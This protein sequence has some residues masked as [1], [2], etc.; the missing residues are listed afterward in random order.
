MFVREQEF[1]PMRRRRKSR[2]ANSMEERFAA[3][4]DLLRLRWQYEPHTF[5]LRRRFD[6]SPMVAFTPDFYLEEFDLYVELTM[7]KRRL[8]TLKNRKVRLMREKYPEHNIRLLYLHDCLSLIRPVRSYKEREKV[9]RRL[10]PW[11]SQEHYDRVRWHRRLVRR[12]SSSGRVHFLGKVLSLGADWA[13]KEC[14]I[15][16]YSDHL[17]IEI[18]GRTI[19]SLECAYDNRKDKLLQVQSK[20]LIDNEPLEGNLLPAGRRILSLVQEDT[21]NASHGLVRCYAQA[22]FQLF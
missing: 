12:V 16:V 22:S 19:A 14:I 17:D 6:G 15:W 4:L 11:A 3:I 13:G 2:F 5:V 21:G 7:H 8:V 10:I 18:E 20:V 9:L 1:S